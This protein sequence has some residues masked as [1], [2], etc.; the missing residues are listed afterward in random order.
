VA[1]RLCPGELEG[2]HEAAV[3]VPPPRVAARSALEEEVAEE[4][5]G[6]AEHHDQA[7]GEQPR[8]ALGRLA[9]LLE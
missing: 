1:A 3:L 2:L 5:E 6:A 8:V 7:D 9:L 4:C